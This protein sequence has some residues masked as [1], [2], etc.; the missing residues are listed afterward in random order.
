MC[1]DS[2]LQENTASPPGPAK[3]QLCWF[4]YSFLS[5]LQFLYAS[6]RDFGVAMYETPKV[7][8]SKVVWK[9]K[10]APSHG[11]TTEV[12]QFEVF[13]RT[14]LN[15]WI[16]RSSTKTL[17]SNT[18]TARIYTSRGFTDLKSYI[19]R[20]ECSTGDGSQVFQSLSEIY[21]NKWAV[22]LNSSLMEQ[23]K[24]GIN[25]PRWFRKGSRFKKVPYPMQYCLYL[26]VRNTILDQKSLKNFTLIKGLVC[27]VST[28][29]KIYI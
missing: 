26:A 23:K 18:A 24:T 3:C 4:T 12:L 20:A 1:V 21:L 15:L 17:N 29:K 28:I 27:N 8:L 6:Q 11:N 25:E 16:N 14:E 5:D 22:G 10:K 2:N 13:I 19:R 7:R 9:K